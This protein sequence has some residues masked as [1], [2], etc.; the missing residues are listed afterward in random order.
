[1]K[2]AGIYGANASGKSN[3]LHAFWFMV[4]YVLT[5]H[6]QQLHKAIERSPFKFDRETPSRPSSFEVIFTT[7]GIRYA[8]GFSVTDK[9]VIEE[10]LYYYPMAGRHSF[11]SEKTQKIFALPLMSMNKTLSRIALR[12][13]SSICL[14]HQTGAIPK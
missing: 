2:S 9:A 14:S 8:Y 7:N 5:S 12:P 1:M 4:N 3:V 10:Y 11:L 6:N 13:T